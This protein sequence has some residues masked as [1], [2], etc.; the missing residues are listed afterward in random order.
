MGS[1]RAAQNT[2][3]WLVKIH[4]RA[5]TLHHN[6]G[7]A[8]DYGREAIRGLTDGLLFGSSVRQ[9]KVSSFN[10]GPL[11]NPSTSPE[12]NAQSFSGVGP[13]LLSARWSKAAKDVAD[14]APR[15]PYRGYSSILGHAGVAP[16]LSDR[17]SAS[18]AKW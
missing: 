17:K 2:G 15:A 9:Y 8:S 6:Q 7:A 11:L 10:I 4:A 18:V 5:S 1:L 16:G 13:E 3:V 14:L 12:I